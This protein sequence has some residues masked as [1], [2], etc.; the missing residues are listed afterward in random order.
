[1]E[2]FNFSVGENF[3]GKRLDV[4]LQN[5][6]KD[7]SRSNIQKLIEDGFVTIN[8][9]I[10]KKTSLKL[11]GN[12]KIFI[13]IQE[14]E[15]KEIKA[16]EIP[17]DVVYEDEYIAVINKPSDMIVHPAQN[18][19]SGTLVNAIL[20]R[21]KKLSNMDSIRPGIV[22]RL[23]KDTSGLIIITKT[24]EAYEEMVKMFQEK[25]MKKIYIAICKGNF[26]EKSGRLENLIGRDPL[27]RKRMAV[28]EK[29]GK[30]AITNYEVIDEVQDFSFL[31]VHIETGRT[32]QIRV[33][34]KYLNHPILGD[35][36]Y[37]SSSKLAKR[38][39]L[40][41]YMLEFNH[42]ITKKIIKVKGKVPKDFEK[43]LKSLKLDKE[44]IE[45]IGEN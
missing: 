43:V 2:K 30:I 34:M 24:D 14:E 15:K 22:H 37:G 17:L 10:I 16:E 40:H 45:M 9:K 19:Y 3:K 28:V 1:M 5:N 23:D 31:K 36:I 42:P 26:G 4:F 44:K 21:F 7:L 33:H 32:H 29:N 39:M 11:K 18:I 35:N 27:E 8:D 41:A 12:E 38:Q 6:L 25:N 13:F 20:Y